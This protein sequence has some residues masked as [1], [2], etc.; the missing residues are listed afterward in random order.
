M[1]S[2]AV[3]QLLEQTLYQKRIKQQQKRDTQADI[4]KD[5]MKNQIIQVNA[6]N[7]QS[8]N[9]NTG[10]S[11]FKSSQDSLVIQPNAT[12]LPTATATTYG[13]FA[14]NLNSQKPPMTQGGLSSQDSID[15][16]VLPPQRQPPNRM[17][18]TLYSNTMRQKNL[19]FNRSN[20]ANIYLNKKGQAIQVPLK[21]QPVQQQTSQQQLDSN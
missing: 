4:H 19:S 20:I 18:Q 15:G 7:S 3:R 2:K 10:S 17:N 14:S 1:K 11:V 16:G 5:I 12:N 9:T 13:Q 21:A 8:N 6:F